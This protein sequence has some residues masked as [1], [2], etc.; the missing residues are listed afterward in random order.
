MYLIR[1]CAHIHT[2]QES[3]TLNIECI[4]TGAGT[5]HFVVDK[6]SKTIILSPNQL[7]AKP[8][9]KKVTASLVWGNGGTGN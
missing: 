4:I 9:K 3:K 2:Y 7:Y 5:E 1:H 8:G 6:N